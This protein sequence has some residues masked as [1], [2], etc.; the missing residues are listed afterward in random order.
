MGA[1]TPHAYRHFISL[2]ETSYPGKEMKPAFQEL[3][4]RV[5]MKFKSDQGNVQYAVHI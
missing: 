5:I 1:E 4:Q 3:F 2:P